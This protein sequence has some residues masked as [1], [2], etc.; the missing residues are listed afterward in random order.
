MAK[1]VLGYPDVNVETHGGFCQF[2]DSEVRLR[3]LGL[4][5]RGHLKSTLATIADGIRLV[6]KNPEH[7]RILI[8][9]ETATQAESFLKEIKGHWETGR[10]LRRLFPELVPDRFTGQ[11]VDWS[12]RKATLNRTAPHKE[13]HWM[14]IGVGGAITGFHFTRIKG[15]DLIGIEASR[16]P[17]RMEESIKWTD[18]IEPLLTDQNKDIIDW[19]GTRWGRADLY[20]HLMDS[21]GTKLAVFLRQAIENGVIIFPQKHTWEGYEFLQTKRPSIWYAQYCNN[22][23]AGGKA[24]FPINKVGFFRFSVDASE[25]IFASGG[26]EKR[27]KLATLD[28][29]ITCDPNSGSATAEN[30][31]SVI[32]SAISPDD[33]VFVLESSAQRFSPSGLVD[34]IF[35]LTMRWRPRVVGIEKAGQQNTEHHFR[36]KMEKEREYFNIQPLSPKNQHKEDRIRYYME[37]IIRSGLLYTLAS[38][39]ALRDQIAAFPD[40]LLWD[41]LDALAYG[42]EVWKR[43][44]RVEDV[45]S[46][47][48]A[49][50]LIMTRR[51]KHSGY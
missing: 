15:D 42:P 22:P 10:V 39:T 25:V 37:P 34:E 19:V 6:A 8:A 46:N 2:F 27:W 20:A 24:D 41:E 44:H 17:A 48:K 26:T 14:T 3:R 29:V 13:S 1:G 51:S 21:Y 30:L 43:P 12:T 31:A 47:R 28:R 40:C 9:S 11:G 23:I 5:P 35:R 36:I 7:E 18:N 49:L 16:S 33:E 4:M 32:V 50:R 45:E 38:E